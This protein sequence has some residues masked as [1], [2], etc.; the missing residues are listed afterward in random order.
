M[1]FLTGPSPKT[2]PFRGFIDVLSHMTPEEQRSTLEYTTRRGGK[3]EEG[4]STMGHIPGEWLIDGN[5]IVINIEVG[6]EPCKLP[7]CRIENPELYDTPDVLLQAEA[8]AR[9][10]NRLP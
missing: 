1:R 5:D 8:N 7:I 10:G 9:E 3:S 2:L 4:E 6:G